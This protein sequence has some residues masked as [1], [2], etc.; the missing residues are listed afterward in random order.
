MSR[1]TQLQSLLADAPNDSFLLFAIA[2]E[3]EGGGDRDQALAYYL[4]LIGNDP[5]YVGA[6]YH[7][8]KLYEKIEAPEK[9]LETY[10]KGMEIAR[11]LGDQHA[12]AELSSAK[13]NLELEM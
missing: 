3:Y 10:A 11:D 6:Y 7:L 13:L 1:L 8:A 5:A 2:K 9:A 4:Q 12:L